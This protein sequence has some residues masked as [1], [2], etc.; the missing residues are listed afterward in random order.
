MAELGEA[1]RTKCHLRMDRI[2][3]ST[4]GG[5]A[6]LGRWSTMGSEHPWMISLGMAKTQVQDCSFP[7]GF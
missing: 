5:W 3:T 4:D 1:A 2:L 7:S 6:L